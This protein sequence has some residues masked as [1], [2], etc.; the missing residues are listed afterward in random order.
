MRRRTH[1]GK[2]ESLGDV[3][4]KI[5]KKRKI[6][7]NL[8]LDRSLNPEDKRITAAWHKA[9][10]ARIAAH[11][12]PEKL[13]RGTLF[14]KVS[15]SVWMQQLH[16]LKQDI[17]GKINPLPDGTAVKNIHFSLGKMP[18]PPAGNES[19]P[20]VPYSLKARDRK[21]IDENTAS[22]ADPELKDILQKV[23]TREITRRRLREEKKAP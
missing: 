5:L 2:I 16:F 10:G 9:V 15:D 4:G 7:L 21:M 11:A 13:Q 23:M 18:A 3:L 17:L 19:P 8:P 1:A 20:V 6:S 22:I 12:S 14:V